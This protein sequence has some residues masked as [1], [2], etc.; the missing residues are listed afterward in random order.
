MAAYVSSNGIEGILRHAGLRMA[1]S[2]NPARGYVREDYLF[3]ECM[4]CGVEAH[5][6]PQYIMQKTQEGEQT[7]RACHWRA[8]NRGSLAV[9]GRQV[10]TQHSE[11]GEDDPLLAYEHERNVRSAQRRAQEHDYELVV[12]LDDGPGDRIVVTRCINCGKQGA[13]RLYDLGRCSCGGPRAREGVS[14]ANTARQVKRE[15]MPHDGSVYENGEHASLAACTSGCLE[16]WDSKRN[17][18]LTPET[19]TRRSQR[20]VWWICP[21]CHLSFVA[22]VY[23]MTWR[24]SCPECE[25]V[26]RLRFSIDREE[27][28]HQ[29]IADYP[30]LLAAWDDEMN[31]FDVPMTDY[32]SYRF[33]CPAGHHPRQTPFSYLDNGCRHCRAART[34][35]DPRQVYLRQTNPEL[36]AEWVRVIGDAE[37]R[38][39]PDN[40]KES[41]RR[42]VVWSCLA[43]GY[44]WT[45][46]PRERGLRI[47]NRCKNCGKVLGSFAW[48]YPSLAEEWDPRNPTSPWNTTPAGRLT[49]K[50]RWI[51][52]RNPDHR[53]EMSIASRVKHSKG[54]PFCAER[55][56]G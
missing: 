55:S 45:T 33:V 50:P 23:W 4:V 16:W 11:G 51:C 28:R 24:P 8:W 49:F 42:K 44:E 40:V 13:R 2:P 7:C 21:E 34:Q 41:S 36:A 46:T 27:R 22:P 25:Q 19:L 10:E 38:Y 17:A 47:N 54:C 53:W 56:A 14:Y 26:Q 18:P 32:R 52:A 5:Y 20:N 30:D 3:T 39:T 31:P 9:Y 15:E 48:K 43:C 1:E 35:A 6:K 29:S 12:L 37:G